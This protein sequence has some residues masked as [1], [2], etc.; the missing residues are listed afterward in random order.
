MS[1]SPGENSLEDSFG[2]MT[3][4]GGTRRKVFCRRGNIC[5]FVCILRREKV[6][7]GCS[8]TIAAIL[9]VSFAEEDDKDC[10]GD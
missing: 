6:L 7:M 5:H 2:R 4:T 1:F 8:L 10:G 9:F 3:S